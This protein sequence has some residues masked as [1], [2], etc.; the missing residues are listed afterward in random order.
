LLDIEADLVS[1]LPIKK[2]GTNSYVFVGEALFLDSLSTAHLLNFV[3]AGNTA[4]LSSK[5]IP[6]DLMFHLYYK[7]CEAAEWND[8]EIQQD[9]QVEV[10]LLAP[11][12]KKPV[13]LHYARQ[14]QPQT[15]RW[16]YIESK[17]F[18]KNLPQRPLGYLDTTRINFAEFPLGAG[19]FLLHTTPIAF[20]NYQ[21][22]RP[23]SR[24]YAE[25]VL[26]HL[27]TGNIYWDSYS[28][29]PEMVARRRNQSGGYSRQLP[30]DH[31]FSFILKQPPLAWAWYLLLGLA[32]AYLVFRA[33]RRQRIIPVLPKNEN[34]SYEFIGTIANLHFREKN[35]QNLCVQNMRLFLAQV[36]ERY[37]LVAQ[38][39]ADSLKP[40]IDAA[41]LER[42]AQVSEVPLK[43]IQGIFTQY[44]AT[45][46]YEPS[47]DMMIQ[48]H[49]AMDRFFNQAK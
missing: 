27:P 47:E 28:R 25:S 33:K 3:K 31:P 42:L 10:S 48:L 12:M 5:T 11:P 9:S 1:E 16:S 38:L 43:Q 8:Y 14:N 24:E 17:F 39:D 13:R 21:L 26:A 32:G 37:G 6:F 22:L 45:V 18:C 19:R 7:E 44:A 30:T 40:R 29:V 49:L 46:Q 20:S 36:R 2:G 4:F 15:Y 35:Y 34:S 23:A 41:F